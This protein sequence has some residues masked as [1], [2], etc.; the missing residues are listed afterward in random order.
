MRDKMRFNRNTSE[1]MVID[2]TE[3]LG[4]IDQLGTVTFDI[5]RSND[6]EHATPMV[7]DSTNVIVNGLQVRCL[8]APDDEW[9]VG[10]YDLYLNLSGLPTL[11][12]PR[13]GP[14]EFIVES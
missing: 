8:I 11:E 5:Y 10:Y 9:E 2:V 12:T 7:T 14:I 1:Y 3:E 6:I 13:L 4:E